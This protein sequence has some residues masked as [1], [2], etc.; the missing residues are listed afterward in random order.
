M[1]PDSFKFLNPKPQ[2]L[3]P[4]C[5]AGQYFLN[6]NPKPYTLHPKPMSVMPDSFNFLERGLQ[7]VQ[8]GLGDLADAAM[9]AANVLSHSGLG[10]E[11]ADDS[12]YSVVIIFGRDAQVQNQPTT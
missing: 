12:P 2:T 4:V 6:P 3:N 7:T 5:D 9:G 8:G 10:D 11:D 1:I